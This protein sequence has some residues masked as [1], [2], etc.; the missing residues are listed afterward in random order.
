MQ[1][2]KADLVGEM[3]AWVNGLAPWSV[4][5]HHTFSWE[6]SLWSS[7]RV[8]ERFMRQALPGLSYF[9]AVEQNPS[10]DGHHVHALWDS[11]E[12]PRKATHKEW[13]KRYGR[14]RIEPC[15]NFQDVVNYCSKYVCKEQAWWDVHLSRSATERNKAS[16]G[17]DSLGG[18]S[19]Y[20]L[21]GG[22][23]SAEDIFAIVRAVFPNAA[24]AGSSKPTL[25]DASAS[26]VGTTSTLGDKGEQKS[27]P[28]SFEGFSGSSERNL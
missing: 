11:T 20:E 27:F 2:T 9:Y 22:A 18:G 16:C 8:Y 24:G 19:C 15:R 26:S 4:I 5:A 10:R 7:R 3:A 23:R 1:Q 14:N 28:L 12:A 6:A 25:M 13:L 21:A 17:K